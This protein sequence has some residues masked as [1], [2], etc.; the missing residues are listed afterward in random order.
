[1]EIS[2]FQA[3]TLI[4]SFAF[5]LVLS[6]II[7][8]FY[9]FQKKKISFL[10]NEREQER[11][12]EKILIESQIEI[13]ENT[14]KGIA[15][16]LHDNVGQLLSLARLELNILLAQNNEKNDKI[17]EIS[18]IIGKSLQEIRAFSKTL[19]QDVV[20]SIGIENA[21]QIEVDRLNRLKFIECQLNVDG[22]TKKISTKDEIILFR[23]VQEFINN[24]IKHSKATQLDIQLAYLDDKLTIK[25]KDNG[26]GFDKEKIKKGSGL[27][28][29]K[30]RAELIKAHFNF[31]SD[32][33]GT[34]VKLTYPF[35][36]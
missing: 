20:Q 3:A 7:I 36:T 13:K 22:E 23:I 24:T 4:I 34:Q 32:T 10:L 2:T 30:S 19:N 18:G 33:S 25:L 14:L 15:W 17:E 8:L 31:T 28:N 6:I 5:F 21:L 12:F 26:V 27:I 1:M 16:E 29:M 35:L 11:K 9:V